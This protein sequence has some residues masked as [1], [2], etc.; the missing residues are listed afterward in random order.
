VAN[1]PIVDFEWTGYCDHSWCETR[2]FRRKNTVKCPSCGRNSV[3]EMFECRREG[4]GAVSNMVKQMYFEKTGNHWNGRRA[5]EAQ[6]RAAAIRVAKE[7]EA[8]R[9]E[10]R[11]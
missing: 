11:P 6:A 7:A 1:S 5:T 10:P 9:L 8:K 4:S 2:S 3:P